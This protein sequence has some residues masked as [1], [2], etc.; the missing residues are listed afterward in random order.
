MN[1]FT[2]TPSKSPPSRH[3]TPQARP[4]RSGDNRAAEDHRPKRQPT[5]A[6]HAAG[7]HPA[8]EDPVRPQAVAPGSPGAFAQLGLSERLQQS[9]SAAGYQTPTPIQT[10]AIP[11]VLTGKDLLG[12]AQTGTGKTAAFA[13]PILQ[14]LMSTAKR[15]GVRALV[16]APT[17]ELAAQIGE[18]FTTYAGPEGLRT[19]V[20]FGGVGKPAQIQALRRGVDILVATPGRLLDLMQ[21]GLVDLRQI[22][23]FVL[24]EADRMLDMGFIHDVRRITAALP[25]QRQNLMFS[26]TMPSE[27]QDLANRIL[28]NPV[29][30]AVD[31]VSSTREPISQSVYFV[32]MAQ[33][34]PLLVELL[35][36]DTID[37][38]LVFTRTKH[39]ANRLAQK[40][41]R[42]GFGAAAIHGNKS[43]SARVRALDDF[44]AGRIRVVVAT[45]IAAR[46][47]DIDGLSH[48]VNFE[49]PNEP[50]SYVHRVG[51]TGRAG[52]AG[53]A[54]SFCSQ[55][56]RAY[57]RDIER[58]TR[59]RLEQR[60]MP[61]VLPVLAPAVD[62]SNVRGT[63]RAGPAARVERVN[64]SGPERQGAAP[65]RPKTDAGAER[66][67]GQRR[68]RRRPRALH[69]AM[70]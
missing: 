60:E 52:R 19:A 21:E 25:R 16:L 69:G 66:S 26:A 59:R 28:R 15:N 40:L 54:I 61:S 14:R 65:G 22:E 58:L 23:A 17:R 38:V 45:D 1:D 8:G 11:H 3:R 57:L 48:V 39:G 34:T 36:G 44:K 55:E 49:L 2:T 20:I 13:L 46:G 18:S 4:T 62:T 24:D 30:V 53:T 68:R 12:S 29:R 50:E 67:S 10:Q 42:A 5:A 63:H 41:V 9:V 35:S 56:E 7:K 51:R 31:P 43:Q 70:G 27:I 64:P 32:E 47:I 33:K 37:R 6:H